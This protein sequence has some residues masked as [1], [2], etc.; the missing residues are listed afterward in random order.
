MFQLTRPVT[1]IFLASAVASVALG[2]AT[3]QA[4]APAPVPVP[5]PTARVI[6]FG[7]PAGGSYLG[8]GVRDVDAG[9]L[10]ELKL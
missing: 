10:R 4:P 1:R 9:R 6:Q 2:V 5:G 8:I 7:S 3:A